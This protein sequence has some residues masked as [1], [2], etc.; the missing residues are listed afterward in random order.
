M[1]TVNNIN[2]QDVKK[3][4]NIPFAV[5]ITSII[6]IIITINTND[7]NGLSGLLGGYTGLLVGL[8]FIV[9]LNLIQMMN[10]RMKNH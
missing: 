3:L 8:L 10:L 4:M 9:I 2:M 1:N 7:K 6:I 5:I